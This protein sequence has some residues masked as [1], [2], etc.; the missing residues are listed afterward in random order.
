MAISI[1][2]SV[3]NGVQPGSDKFAGGTLKCK[4]SQS[5]VTVSLELE[6]LVGG[7]REVTT[8]SY[9]GSRADAAL[10]D[11]IRRNDDSRA[12]RISLKRAM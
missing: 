11:V 3:D 2:P 7:S 1:H 8:Y 9:A 5:P 6:N 12:V 10:A 4:C